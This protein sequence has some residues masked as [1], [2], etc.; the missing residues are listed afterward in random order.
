MLLNCGVGED[1]WESL[2]LQVDQTSESWRKSVLNVHWKDWC[3]TWNFNTL[4][5]WCEELTRWKRPWCWDRLKRE[6]EGDGDDRGWNDCMASP[7]WWTW[8]W[9]SSRSCWWTGKP[10]CCSP[11]GHKES[12]MTKGKHRDTGSRSLRCISKEWLQWAQTLASP[13]TEKSSKFLGLGYLVLFNVQ[14]KLL[15]NFWHSSYLSFVAELLHNLVPPFASSEQFYQGCLRSASKAWSSKNFHII[16][17]N[18]ELLGC[19]CIFSR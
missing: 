10:E 19:M 1:S 3:W 14:K 17:H 16:K 12:D 13:H 4:A 6:G 18:S 9:V 7:T 2:G 11:W 5:T 15:K 8:V